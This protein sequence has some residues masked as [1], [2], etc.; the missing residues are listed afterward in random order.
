MKSF[1]YSANN[2]N[3]VTSCKYENYFLTQMH[4]YG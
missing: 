1:I 3:F 2:W 4:L